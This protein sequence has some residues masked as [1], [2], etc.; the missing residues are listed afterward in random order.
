MLIVNLSSQNIGIL[1]V[2]IFGA[3]GVAGSGVLEI[4]LRHN[5]IKKVTVITRRSTGVHHPKLVEVVHNNF[6]DYLIIENFLKEQ[7]ACFYCL[8]VSQT[9]VRSE[10]E[11][12]EITYEYTMAA[13]EALL[14]IN[15]EIIF[16]FLSGAG[17]DPG[18][19]TRF[20]WARIKGKAESGLKDMPFTR[21]FFFRPGMIMPRGKVRSR[22]WAYRVFEIL[23]PLF[24]FFTP[25][26]VTTNHELGRSMILAALGHSGKEILNNMDIRRLSKTAPDQELN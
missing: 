8:G 16:C 21:L 9:R 11:Y 1:N 4:C 2:I 5:A 23:F 17:T 22:I 13:A 3:T 14:R 20:M 10:K 24:N 19:K 6:K 26:L 25:S 15:R 12:N 18:M 7:D